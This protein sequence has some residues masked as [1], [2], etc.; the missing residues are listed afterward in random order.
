MKGTLDSIPIE[1]AEPT[2]EISPGLCLDKAYDNKDTRE[3]VRT[4]QE[5]R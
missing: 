4:R 3:L 1:R 5:T 2:P